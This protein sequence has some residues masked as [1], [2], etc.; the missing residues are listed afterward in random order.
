[1]S[2]RERAF[3]AL[4]DPLSASAERKF[5]AETKRNLLATACGRVLE[6]GVGTGLSLPHY[7]PDVQLAGVDASRPMLRH[8]EQRAEAL[9]REVRLVQAPAEELPFADGSFDTAVSLAVLC[10]VDDPARAL[11]ELRRVLR[12]GGRLLFIEHVRSDDPSVARR[13]DRYARPW[14]WFSCGC[15]PN[16]DTLAEIEA[17][18]FELVEV[19]R[20]E[21][22]EVP[23]LVRPHVIGWAQTA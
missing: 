17:A 1:V 13:Q 3:A 2:I 22:P 8:A 18:G 5:G 6:I 12:D 19:R 20:E 7:P 10:S 23:R 16:R 4:Y 9:G 11:A 14:G 15:Q 21:R